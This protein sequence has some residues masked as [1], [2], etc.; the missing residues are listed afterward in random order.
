MAVGKAIDFS[1][2]L[3]A[4]RIN[5]ER[6]LDTFSEVFATTPLRA[7][8]ERLRGFCMPLFDAACDG[9]EVAK[10]PEVP[11]AATPVADKEK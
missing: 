7:A 11:A 2:P 9:S 4:S 10:I 3:V 5:L 8:R 1:N 6:T